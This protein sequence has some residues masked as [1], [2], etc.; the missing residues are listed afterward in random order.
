MPADLEITTFETIISGVIA[1]AGS[2]FTWMLKRVASRLDK[3]EE[4]LSRRNERISVLEAHN[5]AVSRRLDR[6]ETKLD[7]LIENRCLPKRQP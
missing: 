2:V 1:T 7:L 6:I 3:I 4:D 5:D